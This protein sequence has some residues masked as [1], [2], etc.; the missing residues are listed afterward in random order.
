M[1]NMKG[2][3]NAAHRKGETE[4]NSCGADDPFNGEGAEVF[5][6]ELSPTPPKGNVPG[7]QP[8]ALP[9]SVS[10]GRSASFVGLSLHACYRPEQSLPGRLPG[11]SAAEDKFPGRGN[12]N[13]HLLVGEQRW[14]VAQA[15]LEG[16]QVRG[17]GG[18]AV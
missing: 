9:R 11:A 2:R 14:L 1:G 5:G 8:N 3:V 18:V 7:G 13:L 10:G 15:G 12:S 4:A 17:G 16:G 6:E